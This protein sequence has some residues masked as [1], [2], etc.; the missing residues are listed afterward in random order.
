MFSINI[1][2]SGIEGLTNFEGE[3]QKAAKEAERDLSAMAY[4]KAVELSSERLHTRRQMFLDSLYLKEDQ[5]VWVVGLGG[6]ARWIDDGMEPHSMLDALLA[7]PK[8]KRAKDGST[9]IVV[10]FEHGPGSG[11]TNTTP[12]QMDLVNEVKSEMKKRKIPW[13]KIERD[14]Q[15][16]PK[17]GALHK[18]TIADRPLKASQ[19]AGQG[20]G[21]VGDVRQGPNE[22]QK[23][24]GGPGG[25]GIPFLQGVSVIQSMGEGGKVQRSVMTFRV[26]SSKHAE[27]GRW[28]HPGLEKVGIIDSVY[29]W[30][31]AEAEKMLPSILEKMLGRL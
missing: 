1:D 12:P 29:E 2:L 13:A 17:L 21:P 8:A 20:W 26:A 25:G 14:D 11:P 10:P 19:G 24:G 6:A 30:A 3:L 7:S 22:R 15:G 9:Y 4:S 16:H 28:K 27:Q 23:A 31:Q 5:G 18:F